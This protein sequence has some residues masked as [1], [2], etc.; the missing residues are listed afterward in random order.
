MVGS[1]NCLDFYH[2]CS[3]SAAESKSTS[4]NLDIG[5]AVEKSMDRESSCVS[6][7]I[8]DALKKT[9]AVQLV[10]GAAAFTRQ[11][12]SWMNGSASC[13]QR[14]CSFTRPSYSWTIQQRGSSQS[15]VRI[16]MLARRIKQVQDGGSSNTSRHDITSPMIFFRI[17]FTIVFQDVSSIVVLNARTYQ[18]EAIGKSA[19]HCW[20][21]L[22]HCTR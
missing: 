11:S 5:Y 21:H 16:Q 1:Y 18:Q 12:H 22:G 17:A 4:T 13:S 3:S 6:K 9:F 15:N 19:L 10:L 8:I 14:R 7:T 20:G 2:S